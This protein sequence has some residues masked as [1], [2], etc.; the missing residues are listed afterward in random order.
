MQLG[1]PLGLALASGLNAYLP[2]LA[3]AIAARF[4]HIAS[5]NPQFAF[6]T[7]NAGIALLVILTIIN[8]LAE[9]VP[10]LDH[11]WNAAHTFIRPLAGILVV[12]ASSNQAA[13]P[14]TLPTSGNV[15]LGEASVLP[16]ITLTA[17]FSLTGIGLLV[18]A[19]CGGL[20]ALMSHAAKTTTRLVSTV[21]T[22]GILTPFVSIS[23]DI[24]AL[25]LVI[26]SLLLPAVMLVLV[27]LFLLFF[28]SRLLRLWLR[29]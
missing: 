7:S 10:L 17:S 21:F 19:L 15:L 3:Y 18:V 12:L 11:A 22:V 23:E 14:L 16:L 6:L 2:L 4:L 8:F 9:K 26:L 1:T 29:H 27:I 25:M 5:V 28:G 13:L 24:L 20:L